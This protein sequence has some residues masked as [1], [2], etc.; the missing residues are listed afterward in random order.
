MSTVNLNDPVWVRLNDL[1]LKRLE[2]E[3]GPKLTAMLRTNGGFYKFQLWGLMDVFGPACRI[4]MS[5]PF[6]DGMVYFKEPA[7]AHPEESV[8]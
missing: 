2:D 7:A 3:Y 1:G 5:M 4:G 6:E 8:P